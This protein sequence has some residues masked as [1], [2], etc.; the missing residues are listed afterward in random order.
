MPHRLGSHH[1]PGV[2]PH[3]AG[4]RTSVGT[5]ATAAGV[6]TGATAA[7]AAAQPHATGAPARPSAVATSARAPGPTGAPTPAS[8][9]VGAAAASPLRRGADYA[10]VHAG[11]S[12]RF[13]P[14]AFWAVAL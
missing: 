1:N 7:G 3:H 4:V 13:G 12:L 8:A 2:Q 11:R 10:L 6:R 9:A 5:G 14:L